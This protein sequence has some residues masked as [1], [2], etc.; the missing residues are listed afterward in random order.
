[1]PSDSFE[2][3][4]ACRLWLGF[5]LLGSCLTTFGAEVTNKVPQKLKPAS[6]DPALVTAANTN[7]I[8]LDGFSPLSSS[9]TN[10]LVPGDSATVLVTFVQK[11][12]QTQWLLHVEAVAPDPAKPPRKPSKF[13]VKSKF[14]RPMKFESKPVPV[15]LHML[16]PF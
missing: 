5:V 11:A 6:P 4:S 2:P 14:G 12:K 15:Q 8:P 1:M 3:Q 9:D 10:G 16:G 13:V 7:Q